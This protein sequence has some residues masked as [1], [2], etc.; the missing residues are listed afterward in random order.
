MLKAHN[1]CINLSKL[2]QQITI[3]KYRRYMLQCS[4]TMRL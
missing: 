4:V 1:P 3:A 2:K